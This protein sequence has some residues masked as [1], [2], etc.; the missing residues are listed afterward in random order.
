[1]RTAG[2]YAAKEMG[3][4]LMF[5]ASA[6][7]GRLSKPSDDK[8]DCEALSGLFAG[9][10]SR[11]RNPGAHTNRTFEDVLQAMEE[12]MLA[13]RLLRIIDERRPT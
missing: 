4:A 7:G 13:S 10:L 3:K 9:A 1:V 6:P 8:A 11:F 5:K 12:L 2:S